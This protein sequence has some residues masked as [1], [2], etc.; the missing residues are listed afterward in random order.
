MAVLFLGAFKA[1]SRPQEVKKEELPPLKALL[2]TGGVSHDYPMRQKILVQGIRERLSRRIEW[3]VRLEGKGN[4][5]ERIPLFESSEWAKGYDIV[6][7]DHC[8]PLAGD[9]A[10]VE[11]VLAPHRSG[12]PSVLIHGSMLS[13]RPVEERWTSFTGMDIGGHEPPRTLMLEQ[14]DSSMPFLKSLDG[15]KIPYEELYRVERK[16]PGVT[17]LLEAR[18]P[19][20]QP[21][22]VAWRHRFEPGGARVFATTLGN[23]TTTLA[24][25][26]FL[27]L[28]AQGFLWAVGEEASGGFRELAPEQSLSGLE[29]T[30]TAPPLPGPGRNLLTGVHA[31]GFVWGSPDERG[32]GLVN[33]GDPM[34]AWR[35]AKAAPG[36]WECRWEPLRTIS[37][38]VLFSGAPV[39]AGMTVEL[40]SDGRSWR[41]VGKLKG[42]ETGGLNLLRFPPET[43]RGLR[44]NVSSM[45]PGEAFALREVA[46][47]AT[48]AAVPAA[49]L[50]KSDPPSGEGQVIMDSVRVVGLTGAFQ[51]VHGWEVTGNAVLPIG[52]SVSQVVPA[53]DGEPFVLAFPKGEEDAG[54]VFRVSFSESEGSEIVPYLEGIARDTLIAWDGEWLYT[55]SG[56]RLDRVRKALGKGPADERQR[57]GEVFRFE[58]ES[59]P[60]NSSIATLEIGEDG[61]LWASAVSCK[62]GSVFDRDGRESTWPVSGFL[63]IRRDGRRVGQTLRQV[64]ENSGEA[65]N[66]FEA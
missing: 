31:A 55:L 25:P 47:Y 51:L 28:V 22:P 42:G 3:V 58:P 62:P 65:E 15:W 46:A 36:W 6:V 48:E 14:V 43:A 27:D 52:W 34:T 26:R 7:H 29:V 4:A 23:A 16:L 20:G 18:D 10:Y 32:A 59:A 8:F 53:A 9:E 57:L 41:E 61:W 24:D 19:A 39:P 66:V 35:P 38:V 5:N 44:V 45:V 11:R 17:S 49:I 13:F 2:V 56:R 63:R 33:D 40:T 54:V 37:R 12:V 21:Y 50:L 1:S 30:D 64:R 60:V